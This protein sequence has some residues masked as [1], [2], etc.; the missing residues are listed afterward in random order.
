MEKGLC[1]NMPHPNLLQ[2]G[3][4]KEAVTKNRVSI[5]RDETF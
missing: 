2:D 3:K 5:L 1:D 4:Q